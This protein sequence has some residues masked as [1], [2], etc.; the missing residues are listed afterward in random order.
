MRVTF[1]PVRRHLAREL[2]NGVDVIGQAQCHDIRI[3]AIDDR[4]ALRTG[5]AVGLIDGDGLA[6]LLLPETGEFRVELLIKLPCR[7]IG[8]IEKRLLL[9][10][11]R[12]GLQR[13]HSQ[14]EQVVV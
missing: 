3:Q 2:G 4:T 8:D 14:K 11:K 10:Q 7:I 12:T 6:G 9:R 1:L 13:S 5:A